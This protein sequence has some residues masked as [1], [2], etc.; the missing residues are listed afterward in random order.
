MHECMR[1]VGELFHSDLDELAKT[2][3]Y[4]AGGGCLMHEAGR[5]NSSFRSGWIPMWSMYRV[6][7][8]SVS[9]FSPMTICWQAEVG[10]AVL[11][12]LYIKCNMLLSTNEILI[13]VG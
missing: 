11:L 3:L 10:K 4:A 7:T 12:E 8:F 2:R 6:L 5:G 13:K 1:R 9:T